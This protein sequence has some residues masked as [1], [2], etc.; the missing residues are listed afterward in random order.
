MTTRASTGAWTGLV[1]VEDT[2]LAVTD[3]GGSGTPVIYLN[4]QFATQGY[5]RRGSMQKHGLRRIVTLSGGGLAASRD[6]P[7]AADRIIRMLLRML[8]GPVLDDAENHLHVLQRSDLDWTVVRGPR[9]TESPGV[10]RYRVGWVGVDA[11]TQISRDDLADF[12]LTQI[13]DRTFVRQMP[14]VSA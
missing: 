5:W 7:K 6:R 8:S 12:I 11:G 4:G 13:D 2:C 9:L 3:S 14:F 10:G 1:P